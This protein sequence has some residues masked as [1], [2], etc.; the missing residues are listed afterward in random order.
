[1]SRPAIATR[2]RIRRRAP[3]PISSERSRTAT[4]SCDA[5]RAL[6]SIKPAAPETLSALSRAMRDS[7]PGVRR[8][9]AAALGELGAVTELPQALKDPDKEI[10]RNAVRPLRRIVVKPEGS[11]GPAAT[12]AV[13]AAMAEALNDEDPAVRDA[14]VRSLGA[15]GPPAR[16]ALPTLRQMRAQPTSRSRELDAA[17]K[18]IDVE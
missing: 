11:A 15:I 12:A 2:A 8:T 6:A 7:D 18:R 13:I 9:A 10:R 1:M 4:A 16:G 5:I 14:A 17:I 3:R